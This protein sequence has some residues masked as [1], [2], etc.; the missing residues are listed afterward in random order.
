MATYA[1]GDLQGCFDEL[2]D[3]LNE[4]NFDPANDRIWFAGDL[5]NRGPKSLECLEFVFQNNSHVK[6]VLGN[7]DLH[8]MAIVEKVRK[9]HAND[10]F[11]EI[12]ASGQLQKYLDW[13]RK[14]PLL[15]HDKDLGFLLTHA[16]LPPQWSVKQSIE[17]ANE[18]SDLLNSKQFYD[19][20]QVIY[21]NN[22]DMWNEKLNG[23]DRYRYIINCF[24][25]MRY[26]N[27][28]GKLEFKNKGAP[29]TQ[30]KNLIPW[31]KHPD[32][33][34]KKQKIIFGH[35]STV[36]LGNDQNFTKWNVYP[37]DTGCLWGGRLTALR[38]EDEKWF[39]VPSR[40][41]KCID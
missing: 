27:H 11:D 36:T 29:G 40:Q 9:P 34:T 33:K 35:W 24:T 17:L 32:R 16:G 20:I 14:Q 22:P 38:L 12:L 21:G 3:M 28:N 15:I 10:T 5:I 2:M 8:L 39:S 31:Y 37:L 6:T 1:I 13:Y 4:I 18:T 30:S 19:F 41:K 7:H 26:C 25:R 23:F